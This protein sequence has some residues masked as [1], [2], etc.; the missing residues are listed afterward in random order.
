[1]RATLTND[2]MVET[3]LKELLRRGHR[4]PEG[5]QYTLNATREPDGSTDFTFSADVLPPTPA[6]PATPPPAAP[7]A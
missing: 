4:F 1:M 6:Q 2:E 3:L 7:R 5:M